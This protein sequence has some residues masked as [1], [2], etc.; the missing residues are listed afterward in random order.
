MENNMDDV[1]NELEIKGRLGRTRTCD[2]TVMSGL[3]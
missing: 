1:M 2:M 3:F